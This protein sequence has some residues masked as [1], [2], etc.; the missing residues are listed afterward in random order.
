[1]LFIFAV[2]DNPI[3]LSTYLI[4]SRFT[5][6]CHE[7]KEDVSRQRRPRVADIRQVEFSKPIASKIMGSTEAL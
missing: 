2:A 1:M 7:L 3:V 6:H 5:R 4:R